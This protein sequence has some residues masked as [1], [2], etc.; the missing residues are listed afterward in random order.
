MWN[1][2]R[3]SPLLLATALRL[4]T[5]LCTDCAQAQSGKYLHSGSG[6]P[7]APTASVRDPRVLQGQ[8]IQLGPAASA[9][10]ELEPTTRGITYSSELS[11]ALRP[12]AV[13][14]GG[15]DPEAPQFILVILFVQHIPLFAAFQDLFLLRGDT[16]ADF[17]LN[18]F[19]VAEH[20]RQNLHDLLANRIAVVNK[21]HFV[22]GHEHVRDLVRQPDNLLS[23]Q[24]HHFRDGFLFRMNNVPSK[25]CVTSTPAVPSQPSLSKDQL[26]VPGQVLLHLLVHFLVRSARAAHFVLALDEDLAHFFV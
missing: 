21:L 9:Q 11:R 5:L 25:N 10:Q 17:Q 19:F 26:A 24:S 18:L 23:A 2:Q 7:K 1:F 13:V 16:L 12:M 4:L 8:R 20:G 14:G 3:N 15:G 6:G 22:A